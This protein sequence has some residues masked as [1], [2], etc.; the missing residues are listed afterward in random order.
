MDS[1]CP[2][3]SMTCCRWVQCEGRAIGTYE[4]RRHSLHSPLPVAAT[5]CTWGSVSVAVDPDPARTS[6][7]AAASACS[8]SVTGD[9]A[10]CTTER[11]AAAM[12]LSPSSPAP[13][14]PQQSHTVSC[15]TQRYHTLA[16]LAHLTAR[17]TPTLWP[18]DG[19][20][21]EQRVW[22]LASWAHHCCPP[23][24][25]C[26]LQQE[27]TTSRWALPL[28]VPL[29]Q[30]LLPLHLQPRCQAR[31]RRVPHRQ[32][33]VPPGGRRRGGAHTRI[34][35]SSA[36]PRMIGAVPPL[37]SP[38]TQPMTRLSCDT[39]SWGTAMA[40]FNA[41]LALAASPSSRSRRDRR[42]ATRARLMPAAC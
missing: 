32:Q 35:M 13:H 23:P 4:R 7:A 39:V 29:L 11:R 36:H 2:G 6:L 8:R 21:W 10:G 27:P 18:K 25:A 3:T 15:R 16:A 9:G 5:R 24:C 28:P 41:S 14:E 34:V 1:G 38:V 40:T 30:P 22:R 31:T 12:D 33:P 37:T 17:Q 42:A 26:E 19:S 20:S